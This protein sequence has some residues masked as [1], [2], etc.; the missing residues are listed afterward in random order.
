MRL[1]GWMRIAI[2]LSAVWLIGGTGYFWLR[3]A[4]RQS[5]LF[6]AYSKERYACIDLNAD[7]RLKKR[8]ELDCRS[9]AEVNSAFERMTRW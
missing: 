2:V 6:A 5:D 7:Y 3:E 8:P 4:N 9:Q 1:N